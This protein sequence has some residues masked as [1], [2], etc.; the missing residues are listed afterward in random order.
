MSVSF[1]RALRKTRLK[2]S[3]FSFAAILSFSV[4]SPQISFL[5][6]QQTK[7]AKVSL[8]GRQEMGKL[9]ESWQ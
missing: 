1:K 9:N 4:A 6:W 8:P 2:V 5:P 3:V 7:V